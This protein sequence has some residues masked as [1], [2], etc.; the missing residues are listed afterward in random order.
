MNL[1]DDS[2]MTGSFE[3]R[4]YRHK[5]QEREE[6][7]HYVDN[8]MIMSVARD[9]LAKLV[10]GDGA[11]KTVKSIGVGTN[12]GGPDPGDTKLTN[13]YTKNVTGRSYP[14]T[15]RVV[16]AF[17]IGLGEANGKAIKEFGLICSDGTRFARKT[18]GTIEKADDIEITGT[19]T[20]N[21]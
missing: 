14:S 11:G 17:S 12:G 5:G 20:I 16:F 15:G 8:N 10:G 3:I 6:I 18:R 13:G 7:E 21:F 2:M 19:W 1:T 4:V 9:A